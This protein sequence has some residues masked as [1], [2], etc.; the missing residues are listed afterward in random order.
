MSEFLYID[1]ETIPTQDEKTIEGL[2]NSVPAPALETSFTP[3]ANYKDPDKIAAWLEAKAESAETDYQA[4]LV[5]YRLEVDAKIH[6]TGLDGGVGHVCCI[7]WALRMR[8]ANALIIDHVKDEAD[9][10]REVFATIEK[11]RTRRGAFVIVGHNVAEFDI[12]FLWHRAFVLGVVMP[13]WFPRDP[14]P[15]AGDVTDT[16]TMWAGS[17]DRISMDRL[18]GYL[19]LSGKGDGIDGSE[20]ASRWLAG[21]YEKIAVYCADDVERTRRMHRKML[22]SMGITPTDAEPEPEVEDE[23][24]F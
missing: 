22:I 17:R 14:K 3:P 2:V 13:P 21:D 18:C 9:M 10:M 12:R 16:M 24:R 8:P 19:G 5:K 7:G 23:V 20:V 4:A 11:E 15:W 1:I 6:K